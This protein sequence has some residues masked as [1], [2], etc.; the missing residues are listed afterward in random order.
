[1]RRVLLAAGLLL[2]SVSPS[3]GFQRLSQGDT[4][5]DFSLVGFRGEIVHLADVKGRK[6]TVIV[7]WATW[8]PRSLE[9]LADLE[10]AFKRYGPEDL[11]VIAVNEE[12]ENWEAGE[13]ERVSSY[14]EKLGLSFSI[15][16]DMDLSLYEKYGVS[17][18]PS[19][20]LLDPDGKVLS[21]LAS[22]PEH[23]RGD[24]LDDVTRTVGASPP[25]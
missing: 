22:Y 13:F 14:V 24:F 16:A 4:V 20:V 6:G 17:V 11:R 7:F 2:A 12:H 15:V 5:A 25:G 9:S 18:L 3:L 8:S 1:M 10:K 23:S 21:T 19:L